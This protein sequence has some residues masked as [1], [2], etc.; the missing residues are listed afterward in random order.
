MPQLT[1]SGLE[2][3]RIVSIALAKFL[4]LDGRLRGWQPRVEIPQRELA[5][6]IQVLA[7]RRELT[8]KW[9]LDYP[10][11]FVDP[12]KVYWLA[13]GFTRA[14][15]HIHAKRTY[16]DVELYTGTEKE[17]KLFGMSQNE[18]HG[19]RRN[20]QDRKHCIMEL[21]KDP[22]WAEREDKWIADQ[23]KVSVCLVHNCQAEILD[24]LPNPPETVERLT[25]K[26]KRITLDRP[27]KRKPQPQQRK[28]PEGRMLCPTCLGKGHIS[29]PSEHTAEPPAA[30]PPAFAA[31]AS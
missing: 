1:S 31:A 20:P 23:C 30:P 7:Q 24:R 26:G 18:Q 14:Y 5:E 27:R 11:A 21:L 3:R 22:V 25:R 13:D 19:V 15:A 16:M 9:A 17:A 28:V 6:Y 8:G 10:I 2:C 29:L 12:Q 4:L